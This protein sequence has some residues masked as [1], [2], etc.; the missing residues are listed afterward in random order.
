MIQKAQNGLSNLMEAIKGYFAD[1]EIEPLAKLLCDAL[2]SDSICY[3]DISID[4]DIMDDTIL[5]AYEKRLL[6]PMKSIRGSAWEDRIL[7]FC[8]GER[9]HLPRVVRIL[10]D[11]AE[12]TSEWNTRFAVR[13]ALAEA[14]EKDI[15]P[16]LHFLETIQKAAPQCVVTVDTMQAVLADSRLEL[17]MHDTLDRFVRCGIMSPITQRSLHTGSPRYEINPCLYWS[18]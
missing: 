11:N 15:E 18:V 9:Y 12:A 16:P 5:L 13:K 6:L 1:E 10:A 3:D 17:D 2:R 7:N 4:P 8:E 14:G